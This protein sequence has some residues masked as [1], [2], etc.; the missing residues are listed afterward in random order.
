M[1][2]YPKG[3][4]WGNALSISIFALTEMKLGFIEW[5]KHG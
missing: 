2:H 1:L 3:K 5:F 4:N